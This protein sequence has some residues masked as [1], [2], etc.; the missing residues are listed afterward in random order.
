MWANRSGGHFAPLTA[1]AERVWCAESTMALTL[2]EREVIACV[3]P[4][5]ATWMRALAAHRIAHAGRSVLKPRPAIRN[6]LTTCATATKSVRSRLDR[7]LGLAR[8]RGFA[9]TPAAP[10][11]MKRS[12]APLARCVESSAS[13]LQTARRRPAQIPSTTA[14]AS[15]RRSAATATPASRMCSA[16]SARGA[17]A[18]PST[19]ASVCR[20]SAR[21]KC[22]S[23]LYAERRGRPAVTSVRRSARCSPT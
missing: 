17:S 4:P 14:A 11:T 12:A 2:A 16:R 8:S 5:A 22:S 3:G 18:A 10:R 19:P 6:S 20:T 9:S 23:R 1:I 13:A 15:V 21:S 7:S